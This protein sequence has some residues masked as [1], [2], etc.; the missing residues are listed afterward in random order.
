MVAFFFIRPVVLIPKKVN[1]FVI[2]DLQFLI[3][4]KY[5]Y[6]GRREN[7]EIPRIK[8]WNWKDVENKTCG[9]NAPGDRS[10]R[11][12]QQQTRK[13]DWEIRSRLKHTTTTKNIL[14]GNCAYFKKGGALTHLKEGSVYKKQNS[15]V[16]TYPANNKSA[17]RMKT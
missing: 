1:K 9:C 10:T 14:T 11:S 7:W 4:V 17:V 2:V 6:Q 3:L 15:L 12:C 13:L 16:L 8:D 5:S